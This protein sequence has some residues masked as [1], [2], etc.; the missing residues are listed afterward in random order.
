MNTRRAVL[1]IALAG[2]GLLTA[3]HAFAIA[4]HAPMASRPDTAPSALV[5]GPSSFLS[6]AQPGQWAGEFVQGLPVDHIEPLAGLQTAGQV[7]LAYYATSG[8]FA[9]SNAG[10]RDPA[11]ATLIESAGPAFIDLAKASALPADSRTANPFAMIL[12]CATLI[13]LIARQRIGQ[14]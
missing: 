3:A 11:G 6:A 10:V 9:L 8:P 14:G 5:S 1:S 4:A 12:A 2:A 7:A 13:A